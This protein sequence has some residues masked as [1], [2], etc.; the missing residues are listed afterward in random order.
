ME[1]RH[2]LKHIVNTYQF[3]ILEYRL[4]NIMA[5]DS[6]MVDGSYNIR[7]IYFDDYY[8]S[9]VNENEA[10]VNDRSKIRIR[11]YDHSDKI[12]KLE[13]KYK[14]NGMTKKESCNLTR[15]LCETIIRGE[16]PSFD[17]CKDNKVLSR[18][19]IEMKTRLLKPRVIVEYDRTPF[20]YG[21]GN[22]RVTFDKNI[23]AS[24]RFDLFFEDNINA[25]PVLEVGKHVLE[26]K[27]DEFIPDYI[28]QTLELNNLEQTSFSKYYLSR[29]AV[30]GE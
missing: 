11:I 14:L 16:C 2:E 9:Y 6:H 19:Y 26:V 25:T 28:S 22:I 29:I 17:I 3:D 23:R 4:R 8:D 30:G 18:L 7:S 10:G 5:L 21:P 12:I 15:E 27:Y 20:I 13:I 1:Y 24:K